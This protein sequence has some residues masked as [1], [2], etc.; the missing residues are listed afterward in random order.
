MTTCFARRSPLV[1]SPAGMKRTYVFTASY[2]KERT[3]LHQR[4]LLGLPLGVVLNVVSR[5]TWLNLVRLRA[6]ATNLIL[7]LVVGRLPAFM[8]TFALF[9]KGGIQDTSVLA[10]RLRIPTWWIGLT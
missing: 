3:E 7:V 4:F 9:V 2:S 6:F 1:T 10:L 8:L 5:G